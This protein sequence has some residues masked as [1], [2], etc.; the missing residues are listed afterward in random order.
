MET[1]AGP[2]EE[3]GQATPPGVRAWIGLCLLRS[4]VLR[5]ASQAG[6]APEVACG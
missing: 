2:C 6:A 5:A 4:V 3:G 1:R